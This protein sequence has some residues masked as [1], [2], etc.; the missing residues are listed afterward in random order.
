MSLEPNELE[1]IIHI[2]EGV[3]RIEVHIERMDSE[4]TEKFEVV[5]RRIDA[6]RDSIKGEGSK[7]GLKAGAYIAGIIGSGIAALGAYFSG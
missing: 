5:N 6:T 4:T 1:Q 3:A 2:R 7:A